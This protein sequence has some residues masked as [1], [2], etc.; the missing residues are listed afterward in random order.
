MPAQI[1]ASQRVARVSASRWRCLVTSVAVLLLA[2]CSSSVPGPDG[3]PIPADLAAGNCPPSIITIT[4]RSQW[5]TSRYGANASYE[6]MRDFQKREIANCRAAVAKSD[7]RA[8]RVLES[9]WNRQQDMPRLVG[10]FQTYLESSGD[11]RIKRQLALE[12]YQLYSQ[13]RYDFRPN[14]AE[15]LRYLGMAVGYGEE[16]LRTEYAARLVRAGD[17]VGAFPQYQKL[18]ASGAGS[19]EA[20]CENLLQLGYLHFA[21]GGTAQN[22]Y[23]GYYYWQRGLALAEDPRWGSCI[24]N[25]MKDQRRYRFE[26]DRLQ[27]VTPLIAQLSPMET[28]SIRDATK[29][30]LAQGGKIVAGMNTSP[31]AL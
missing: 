5:D 20:R 10:T 28:A 11:T 12:L 16:S 7:V 26:T 15:A 22:S 24:E 2:A 14:P 1:R 27:Y 3:K 23:L 9:H 13:G 8:L 6:Q 18:V 19:R 17:Y 31:G 30:N 29:L 21:G 4:N 25:N